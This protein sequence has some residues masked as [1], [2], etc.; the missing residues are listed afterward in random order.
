MRLRHAVW[1]VV[2]LL[3]VFVAGCSTAPA[4]QEEPAQGT[5]ALVATDTPAANIG[6][7]EPTETP[8]ASPTDQPLATA[9]V[10][11]PTGTAAASTIYIRSGSRIMAHGAAQP[12]FIELQRGTEPGGQ[13]AVTIAPD[14]AYIAY[15]E[16]SPGRI[17]LAL[18]SLRT[19][20]Q[21]FVPEALFGGEFSPDG[22]SVVYTVVI[23]AGSQV[24]ARDLD[25]GETR[26]LQEGDEMQP[27]RPI[28]W[29]PA[30]ILA[31][32]VLMYSDAPPQ[33]LVMIDPAGGEPRTV[34]PKSHIQ[35]ESAPDGSKVALIT[36]H[37]G[38]GAPG[39]AGLAVVDV[40]TGAEQELV[41]QRVGL[42]PFVRWS[43]DGS[44]LL[45]SSDAGNEGRPTSLHLV[46]A[47]G[48]G[49]DTLELA[50]ASIA[51]S[52]RD[53]VW[54]DNRTLLVLV[55][56]GAGMLRLYELAAESFDAANMQEIG[57]FEQSDPNAPEQILLA[58]R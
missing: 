53:V 44:T 6:G 4:A 37:L 42:I 2:C 55:A 3:L 14:G 29:T 1:A 19:S 7:T 10:A 36:G 15:T 46:A 18:L 43:P 35:G 22:R 21:Q 52:V 34:R 12:E 5:P 33:S 57:T 28:A 20:Q 39:E 49:G 56:G 45:Y 47:D 8:A 51:G 9:A 38:I 25:S 30:G 17:G 27:L 24:S 41:S 40:A 23:Q 26:V 13:G 11:T 50:D 32:Q 54:S 48:S 31:E 58:R 16:N